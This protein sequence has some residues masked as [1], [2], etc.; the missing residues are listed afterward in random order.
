MD[1]LGCVFL[2][3]D[4]QGFVSD[5]FN[6]NLKFSWLHGHKVKEFGHCVSADDSVDIQTNLRIHLVHSTKHWLQRERFV[7]SRVL[8]D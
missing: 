4:E 1:N 2:F 6:V 7:S 3:P 5:D 8:I